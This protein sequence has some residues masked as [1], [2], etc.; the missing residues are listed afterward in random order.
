M[1]ADSAEGARASVALNATITIQAPPDRVFPMLTPEGERAW[2]TGWAPHY[3]ASTRPDD[4]PGTAFL[5]TNHGTEA[6]W[7]IAAKDDARHE[8]R[9]VCVIP[10]GRASLISVACSETAAGATAA[11][12]SYAVTALSAEWDER[13][14][15]LE[16][17]YPSMMEEWTVAIQQAISPPAT[18]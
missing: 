2:V 6:V 8:A 4:S 17:A 11:T 18:P 1:N 9:Y 14:R 3:P 12:I 15:D 5:T 10:G 7:I 13:V 16:A